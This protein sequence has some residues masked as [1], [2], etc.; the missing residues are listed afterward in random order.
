MIH[1]EVW[2]VTFPVIENLRISCELLEVYKIHPS[3]H[4]IFG[5]H[6]HTTTS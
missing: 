2:S 6:Y 1:R 5:G 4:G 3:N